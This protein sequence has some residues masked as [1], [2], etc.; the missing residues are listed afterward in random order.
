MQPGRTS[1]DFTVKKRN[2]NTPADPRY[3]IAQ[4]CVPSQWGYDSIP[5][6]PVS[7]P[8]ALVAHCLVHCVTFCVTFVPQTDTRCSIFRCKL[9]KTAEHTRSSEQQQALAVGGG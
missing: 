2:V 3:S 4:F 1:D 6:I 8:D 7:N 5:F 9:E